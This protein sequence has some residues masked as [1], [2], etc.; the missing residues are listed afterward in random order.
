MARGWHPWGQAL[1]GEKGK[2]G[3]QEESRSHGE[4]LVS[5]LALHL[6]AGR[7]KSIFSES[8]ISGF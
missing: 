4:D 7:V 1:V 3:N 2:V 6:S 5:A 8:G